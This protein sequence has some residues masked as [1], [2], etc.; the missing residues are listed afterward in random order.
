[1]SLSQKDLAQDALI[2]A[3]KQWPE[4]GVP[5]NPG[6]WLLTVAKHQEIDWIRRN[7]LRD[8]KYEEVGR[9]LARHFE[10]D[11]YSAF[12]VDDNVHLQCL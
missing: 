9:T 6:A 2:I 4:T 8:K 7:R 12:S 11:F 1:M 10:P 5:E 3:L